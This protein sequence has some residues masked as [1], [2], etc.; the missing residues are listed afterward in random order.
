MG[1][2]RGRHIRSVYICNKTLCTGH[3]LGYVFYVSRRPKAEKTGSLNRNLLGFFLYP[4][5]FI[6]ITIITYKSI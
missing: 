4:I 6:S 1:L 3:D 5:S 2:Y